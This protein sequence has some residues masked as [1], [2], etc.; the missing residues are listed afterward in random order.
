MFLLAT[1]SELAAALQSVCP[2]NS[3]EWAEKV[4]SERERLE[5]LGAAYGDSARDELAQRRASRRWSMLVRTMNSYR[6][7]ATHMDGRPPAFPIDFVE[8]LALNRVNTGN[9][10]RYVFGELAPGT[11]LVA[12]ELRD[13][14]RW[15]PVQ[16]VRAKSI[17]DITPRGSRTSC[18][19][20][21][22]L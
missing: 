1:S 12:T 4:K 14:Y 19:V 18:D 3:P 22:G 5:M 2:A 6:D 10:G 20:A 9:D 16:V 13:E 11:Y 17:A 7:S 21:R 8:K 15:V